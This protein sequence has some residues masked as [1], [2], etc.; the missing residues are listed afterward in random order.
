MWVLR[1]WREAKAGRKRQ[2]KIKEKYID[3]EE[4]NK[5]KPIWTHNP[6]NST[7]EYGE[8]YKNLTITGRTIWLSRWLLGHPQRDRGPLPGHA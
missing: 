2:K 1:R 5:T 7:Q 6:D 8:L 4:L 3:Q